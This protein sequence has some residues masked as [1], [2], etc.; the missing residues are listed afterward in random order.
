MTA[1]EEYLNEIKPEIQF[2]V[3]RA[4]ATMLDGLEDEIG[5]MA[6]ENVYKYEPEPEYKAMRRYKIGSP[7]NLDAW[8]EPF[9]LFVKNVTVLQMGPGYDDEVDV[10]EKALP[11]YNQPGE[12]PFLD[13]A[14]DEYV[15]SG[16]G[17][18]EL[19]AALESFGFTLA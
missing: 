18:R 7:E 12:R 1:L 19:A 11:G 16:R 4:F 17:D 8:T 14:L 9:M 10:V 3:D 5:K 15:D 13:E 2:S 6:K